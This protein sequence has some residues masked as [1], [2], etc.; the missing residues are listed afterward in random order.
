M[1]FL[2]LLILT[3]CAT[4]G[5]QETPKTKAPAK[6]AKAAAPKADAY[7]ASLP[8]PTQAGVR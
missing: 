8:K 5:A 7:S 2:T 6:K 4:L 3:A 1:K